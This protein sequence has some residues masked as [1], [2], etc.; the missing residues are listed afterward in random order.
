MPS[1]LRDILPDDVK[2]R[3]RRVRKVGRVVIA[4][5]SDVVAVRIVRRNTRRTTGRAG[6]G[7]LDD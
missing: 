7:V 5:L 6:K 1:G 4:G 2:G 3:K